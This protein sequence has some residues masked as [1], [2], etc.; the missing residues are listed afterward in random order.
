VTADLWGG[1]SAYAL[2]IFWLAKYHPMTEERGQILNSRLV[3]RTTPRQFINAP[4]N[5]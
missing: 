5:A 2:I 1:A 3:S 4:I